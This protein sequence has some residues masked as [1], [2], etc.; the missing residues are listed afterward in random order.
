LNC[1]VAVGEPVSR[2]IRGLSPEPRRAIRKA[3][4]A[5]CTERGDI[6]S[7][8]DELSGFYRVRVGKYRILF[9][10]RGDATIEVPYIA[11]RPVVYEIFE[12]QFLRILKSKKG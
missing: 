7:L 10:Y 4:K 5:L 6:R 9:R 12:E 11:E 2:Y 3:L 8:E 1:K